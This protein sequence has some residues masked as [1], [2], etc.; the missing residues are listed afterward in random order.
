[1]AQ[2]TRCY[3]MEFTEQASSGLCVPTNSSKPC[4]YLRNKGAHLLHKILAV[5]K[6]SASSRKLI[7]SMKEELDKLQ[8]LSQK[9][10]RLLDCSACEGFMSHPICLPCGHSLCHLCMEKTSEQYSQNTIVCPRCQEPHSKIPV[11]FL[12]SRKPTLLLQ[13]LYQKCCPNMLECCTYREL[14]N[15]FAQGNSF[16]TAIEHYNTAF[17]TGTHISIHY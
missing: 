3:E 14:G 7:S 1:M 6:C 13:S 12:T 4:V 10:Y 2:G 11:G 15:K 16:I 5:A 17:E 8:P 9:Q